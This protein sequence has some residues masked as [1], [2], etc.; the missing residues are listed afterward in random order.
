[1]KKS[2]SNSLYFL[3][4]ACFLFACKS[5]QKVSNHTAGKVTTATV[6]NKESLSLIQ[7]KQTSFKTFSTKANTQLNI[8]NKS[9]DVTLNIRIKSG[10]GI[11]VSVTYFAGIEVA[12]ALITPDSIKV[13]D[14]VNDE[15]LKKPFSFINKFASEEIDYGTLEAVFLGNCLPISLNTNNDFVK[16]NGLLKISGQKQQ[17]VFKTL[18]NPELKPANTQLYTTDNLKN[19]NVTIAEFENIANA[20]VP[21]FIKISSA[22]GEETLQ[23]NMEYTKT[24][25]NEPVDFPFN[26]SKRFSVID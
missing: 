13:M 22:A 12:R 16:E 25:L 21:K 20:L 26:V 23:L 4:I 2:I 1:M 8:K 17:L 18:F 6:N 15:Y 11:W 10:E 9:Y 14:K 7:A 24:Q 3:L 19:L 5:K